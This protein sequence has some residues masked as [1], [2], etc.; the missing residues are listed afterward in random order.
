MVLPKDGAYDSGALDRT[1]Q[2][3]GQRE[4]RLFDAMAPSTAGNRL[5]IVVSRISDG[6]PGVFLNYRGVGSVNP[7][8]LYFRTAR[9]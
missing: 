7:S 9:S 1:N 5:T 2:N 6:K 3:V 8:L 4:R